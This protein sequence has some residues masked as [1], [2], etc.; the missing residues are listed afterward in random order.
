M[1][2]LRIHVFLGNTSRDYQPG[3]ISKRS[4]SS[5]DPEEIREVPVPI[6]KEVKIVA[7]PIER[8]EYRKP[9]T[10]DELIRNIN[11]DEIRLTQSAE[12]EEDEESEN[13]EQYQ[14]D[15]DRLQ[16][17]DRK[18]FGQLNGF[19]EERNGNKILSDYV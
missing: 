3:H 2:I 6:R 15:L 9:S 7:H 17:D 19:S 16:I 13:F 4:C 12:K 11:N 1:K 10:F 5:K 18:P 14:L 8:F